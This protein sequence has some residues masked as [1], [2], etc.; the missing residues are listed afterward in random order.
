VVFFAI[1]PSERDL[2][3]SGIDFAFVTLAHYDRST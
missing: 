2:F 3:L 1:S